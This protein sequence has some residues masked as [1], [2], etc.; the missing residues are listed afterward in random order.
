MNKNVKKITALL[1]AVLMIAIMIPVGVVSINAATF[2]ESYTLGSDP[3]DNL[4]A[5]AEAQNTRTKAEMGYTVPW[6]ALFVSDCAIRAG[7]SDVIP[8]DAY[9]GTLY[10]NIIDAG[11]V[12]VDNPQ[13]GDIVFYYCTASSCPDSGAPWV[14]VGIMTSSSSSIEGNSGG[15]VTA[16]T[17]ITYTDM[18]G[19]TYGHSGTNSVIVKY[20][21]PNYKTNSHI[22]LGDDFY[23]F[24][25]N[26]EMWKHLT[27][28][29]DN[30]VVIRGEKANHCADQVWKF[31]RQSDGSYKI[32]SLAN[33]LCLDVDNA[34]SESGTNVK[35]CNDNGNNAQRWYIYNTNNG[36]VLK[37]KCSD[38]VLDILGGDSNDGTNVQMFA[39]ND[40]YAQIF[41]VYQLTESQLDNHTFSA[42]LGDEFTAPLLNL[43]VWITLENCDNGDIAL[44]NETGK[45]NQL[46][47]FIRQIDG[48]YKIY[49]CY[50]GRCIDLDNAAHENGTNIKICG[51]NNNDAQRWYFYEY[52]G[53]YSIQSKASGK[54]FDVIGGKLYH[55]SSIQAWEWNGTDAQVFAVYRGNECKLGAVNL[56]VVPNYGSA[57]FAWS[58]TYGETGYALKLWRGTALEGEPYLVQKSIPARTNSLSIDLPAGH[59]EGY[60]LSQNYY[61]S[62]NSNTVSFDVMESQLDKRF[63]LG[64]AD[65]DGVITILDATIIQRYLA[66][67]KVRNSEAV[68]VCGDIN[69]DGIDIPDATLI[70]RHLAEL[71]VPYNI[72]E[73]FT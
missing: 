23:A 12:E 24:I 29:Q 21:R 52:G 55:G 25:I 18:N 61:E 41:T 27:V 56:S 7:L 38:C 26:T 16:K 48:S 68:E 2:N 30:N 43:K 39:R 13:R 54:F 3:I 9:C 15:K 49:S 36:V 72:G 63:I 58:T 57:T 35:M 8:G 20:L 70:Q 67:F 6:C 73:P 66:G 1:L 34:S 42:N 47:R 40:T 10:Q 51:S 71:T 22:D 32:I 45:S 60:I 64:D 31:E 28:E 33:G 19:H 37:S 44:Q 53:G 11:G 14:H 50:D 5:V 59:Y 62:Y 65:G 46:W 69:G 4:I 17:R